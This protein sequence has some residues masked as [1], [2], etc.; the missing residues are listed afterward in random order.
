MTRRSRTARTTCHSGRSR[1]P[2]DSEVVRMASGSRAAIASRLTGAE[3]LAM[4]S[5]RFRAP[6]RS[7]IS[8]RKL[9]RPMVIGG[10]SHATISTR[11][12]AGSR[13][14]RPGAPVQFRAQARGKLPAPGG[15]AEDF[16]GPVEILGSDPCA[17]GPRGCRGRAGGRRPRTC[18]RSGRAPP[19][20]AGGRRW[21][22]GWGSV[23]RP[24]WARPGPRRRIAPGGPPDHR[25]TGSEREQR[26]GGAGHQGH[27]P[28]GRLGEAYGIPGVIHE[29]DGAG[30]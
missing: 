24:R 15:P 11:G 9:P 22:P 18:R 4:S 5:N 19:D 30:T 12:P 10:W 29:D 6:A 16:E 14:S 8:C 13:R 20:P 21:L 23:R 17:A 26:L 27:D 7:T 25:R 1:N 3:A 2:G 28:D